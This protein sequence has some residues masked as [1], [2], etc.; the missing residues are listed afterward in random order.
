MPVLIS[1]V[2]LIVTSTEIHLK[3]LILSFTIDAKLKVD[4]A[5]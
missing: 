2:P 3:T 1:T 4:Q 5:S